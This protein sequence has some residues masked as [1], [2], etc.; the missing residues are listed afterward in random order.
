L[1]SKYEFSIWEKQSFLA[2]W[3]V[4]IT[5]AGIVGLSTALS[6][7]ELNP[8]LRIA[9]FERGFLPTGASTRNAGFACFGSVSELLDDLSHM[10]ED[11]VAETVQMRWQGL[12]KLIN[13]LGKEQ[14]HYHEG[15]GVEVFHSLDQLNYC[16][17]HIETLNQ[18]MAQWIGEKVVYH[19]AAELHRRLGFQNLHG[20]ILNRAEGVLHP[21]EMMRGLIALCRRKDISIFTGLELT[22]WEDTEKGV[23]LHMHGGVLFCKKLLFA[24]NGFTPSIM[25]IPDLKPARNMVLLTSPLSKPLPEGIG[26]HLDS[27]YV[28]WRMLGKQ[29]L[30]GGARNLDPKT[31][32]STTFGYNPIIEARLMDLLKVSILPDQ[33]FVIE[34]RW[35]GIMGV[36]TRKKP[37]ITMQSSNVGVA[38]RMGGMGV[39]IGSL[40]GEQA[41]EML[42]AQLES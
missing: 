27:G 18:K 21:G 40:V 37:I 31:E 10:S 33:Q 42:F 22:H 24:T 34:H 28:Y 38:V 1:E 14:I 6:L 15:G 39:A 5:G 17:D 7:K 19:Y 32:E 9:I 30:I 8:S 2:D 13:R 29:L 41:S 16:M 25:E 35:S 23:H 26:F 11:V 12:Q 36:G 20:C 3:D 4:C